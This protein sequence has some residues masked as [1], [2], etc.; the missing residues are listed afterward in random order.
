MVNKAS[1][2]TKQDLHVT[3]FEKFV[4]LLS[5]YHLA[6]AFLETMRNPLVILDHELRVMWANLSFYR[7]FHLL[8]EETENK[9]IYEV[10]TGEWDIPVFQALLDDGLLERDPVYNVKIVRE[11][12]DVGQKTLLMSVHP[13]AIDDSA[14]LFFISIDD[15]SEVGKAAQQFN[16]FARELEIEKS[17]LK[18]IVENAPEAIVVV[19]EQCR[20]LLANQV[21]HELYA[22]PVPYKQ[23]L[24]SHT[25]LQL[26]YI[27]GTPILPRDLP[28]SRSALN[29]ETCSNQEMVVVWPNGERRDL[30]VNSAPIK[31]AE[32]TICGAVGVFQ[33][34]TPIKDTQ[35]ERDRLLAQVQSYA[36]QL[37]EANEEL[38]VQTES[39]CEVRENLEKIVQERTADLLRI[40]QLL[41]D[42]IFEHRE[43]EKRLRE[44]KRQLRI[45][46]SRLVEVQENERKRIAQ[47][48]HDS[49]GG[50]LA[51]IKFSLEEKLVRARKCGLP[52]E[53]SWEDTISMVRHAI[54][55]SRGIS[56]NL[57]PPMID[58]LGILATIRWF[59]REFQK[60]YASIRIEYR[61]EIEEG[62][63]PEPL[64]IVIYRI[65][66]EALNNV[67][68]H[69]HADKVLIFLHKRDAD[70]MLRIEDNGQGFNLTANSDEG[71]GLSGMKDRATLSGGTIEIQ[72]HAGKGTTIQASWPVTEV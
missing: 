57:R 16:Q 48:L 67:A 65:L 56:T 13:V 64:K 66:Q 28:L 50:S 35:R 54:E 21:A 39:L 37:K 43:T 70:I 4:D 42:E 6:E 30:L 58:D 68:K 71:I 69:S 40:N 31:T 27:D 46:S 12:Q 15:I 26:C 52:L 17:R 29:G 22:R 10:G 8:P 61:K 63:M 47:E 34:I 53:I 2:T 25:A 51:A 36:D 9:V 45:L 23:N 62:D 7:T 55:E 3:F 11:F 19:D 60:V 44:S 20:I 41:Q 59:C 18:S 24:H 5:S 72:S 49:I 32:G 14:P 38:I 33:D 1:Q